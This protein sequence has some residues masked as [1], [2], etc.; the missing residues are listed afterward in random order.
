MVIT[1]YDS[2]KSYYKLAISDF[3]KY[4]PWKKVMTSSNFD[5]DLYTSSSRI[6]EFFI[7][8]N[9]LDPYFRDVHT[10]NGD[11]YIFINIFS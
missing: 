1:K 5:F 6:F 2:S 8:Q 11:G 4:A 9:L 10:K 3:Q 7:N